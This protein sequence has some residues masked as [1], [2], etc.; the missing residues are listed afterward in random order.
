MATDNLTKNERREAAREKAKENRLKEKK[1]QRRNRWFLQGGIALG[2]IAIAAVVLVIVTS[3]TS[4]S[5]NIASVARGPKNMVSDGILFTQGQGNT[6]KAVTTPAIKAN[7]TPTVTKPKP[8]VA[9]I[10]TYVDLQCPYCQQFEATNDTQIQKMVANGTA[11][12]EVHPIAILD[13]SSLG[14]LY[15]TRADNALACVAEY[16]PNSFLAVTSALYAKQPAENTHG[17]SD[18]ALINIVKNAGAN[19]TSITD[20]ISAQKFKNWTKAS[21]QRV[22]TQPLPNS[23][24]PSLTGT[25]TILVNGKQYTGVLTDTNTFASFVKA[26]S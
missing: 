5:A 1:Q 8:G 19:D 20:C 14:N 17:M 4:G 12:L 26:N 9:N 25:P 15:A 10:V 22:M 6:V 13:A 11:T 16:K 3:S 23:S 18:H 7:G 24:L 2:V 21:S